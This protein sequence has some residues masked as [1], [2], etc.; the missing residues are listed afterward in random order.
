MTEMR[1]LLRALSGASTATMDSVVRALLLMTSSES[2]SALP[3][4][5][6]FVSH[7]SL[8]AAY[9]FG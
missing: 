3:M 6:T 5:T 9:S 7:R 1:E 2:S 8:S 4:R